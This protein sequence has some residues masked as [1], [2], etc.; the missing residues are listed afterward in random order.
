MNSNLQSRIRYYAY[1]FALIVVA[2]A[3]LYGFYQK[4]QSTHNAEDSTQ[5]VKSVDYLVDSSLTIKEGDKVNIDFTGYLD[6]E[7]MKDGSTNGEGVDIVVGDG[8]MMPEI[9]EQLVGHHPGEEYSFD[10]TF[11]DDYKGN[12]DLI[13]KT[14][15]IDMIIHGVYEKK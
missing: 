4:F 9:E 6:G 1:T 15:T 8:K 3:A 2:F 7:E 10:L 11:G 13:G 12:K 14:V 5:S